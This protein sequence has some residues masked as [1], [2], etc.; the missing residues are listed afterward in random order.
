MGLAE[1]QAGGYEVHTV[2]VGTTPGKEHGLAGSEHPGFTFCL[3]V[4]V[5]NIPFFLLFSKNILKLSSN[6]KFK[7]VQGNCILRPS[8]GWD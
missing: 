1:P 5:F 8:W 2:V 3:D 4:S 6:Q 7:Q